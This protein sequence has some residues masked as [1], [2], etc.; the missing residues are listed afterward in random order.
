VTEA[1]GPEAPLTSEAPVTRATDPRPWWRQAWFS[2]AMLLALWSQP[3]ESSRGPT[4]CAN[5]PKPAWMIYRDWDWSLASAERRRVY[6]HASRFAGV[7]AAGL[8]AL[9][10]IVA[11]I[12]GTVSP[13]P[14]EVIVVHHGRL[15]CGPV[16][17]SRMFT[18]V[19]QVMTVSS[20]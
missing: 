14:T 7:I 11:V 6:L 15:S 2:F 17:E 8:I 9:L 19:T 1:A 5:S 16:S 12:A 13:V 20:C 18:G 3:K 10:A 4:N